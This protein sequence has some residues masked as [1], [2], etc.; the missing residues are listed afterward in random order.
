MAKKYL[1]NGRGGYDAYDT[2]TEEYKALAALPKGRLSGQFLDET[3]QVVVDWLVRAAKAEA[4]KRTATFAN[5]IRERIAGS[6]HYLQAARWP[7]Q[8][9]A[10]QSIKAGKGSEFD[11]AI[12]A[13]E[14]RLRELGETVEQLAD[15]V[16]ANSLIFASFGAAVDGV[17]RATMDKITAYKGSDP[18]AFDAILAAA[19]A[20][21]LTEFLDIF[22][23]FI[24]AEAA[25]S[26]AAAFFGG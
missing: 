16:L 14:A 8:L 6:Q 9:V 1:E 13:R 25:R 20:T 5:L 23:P 19:K 18:A 11:R 10:A 4:H 22:T 2:T 3:D 26:K 21:A 7:I 24:G 17:E 12:M 15:K